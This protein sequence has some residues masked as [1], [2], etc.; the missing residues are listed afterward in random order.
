M[1]NACLKSIRIIMWQKRNGIMKM[2]QIDL[3]FVIEP[4]VLF[5][6]LL[7][8]K[9]IK[10][11]LLFAQSLRIVMKIIWRNRKRRR[12][13]RTT[14]KRKNL[15]R[16]NLNESLNIGLHNNRIIELKLKKYQFKG[17]NIPWRFSCNFGSHTSI[18]VKHEGRTKSM[19]KVEPA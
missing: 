11:K 12:N 2:T 1:P 14:R 9:C 18:E 19:D 17:S 15:R 7:K 4:M 6:N 10:S 5:I 16:C 13:D 3:N 8:R